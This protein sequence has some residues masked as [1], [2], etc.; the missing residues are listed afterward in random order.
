MNKKIDIWKPR[1]DHPSRKGTYIPGDINV[2]K[3]SNYK[4]YPNP[5][6]CTGIRK[7]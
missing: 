5:P 2:K 1:N 3:K 7:T 4:Y 6:G